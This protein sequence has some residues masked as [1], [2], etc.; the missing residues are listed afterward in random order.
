M[1]H[2][3]YQPYR[4]QATCTNPISQIISVAHPSHLI[5]F[6][7]LPSP[8]SPVE[9][10]S[11]LPLGTH[12]PSP[13]SVMSRNTRAARARWV[14][15]Y[16]RAGGHPGIPP[17]P[18][19]VTGDSPSPYDPYLVYCPHKQRPEPPPGCS[20]VTSSN[21]QVGIGRRADLNTLCSA[22][23]PHLYKL[24]GYLFDILHLT[25]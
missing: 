21:R 15:R 22:C 12:R 24:I 4:L 25:K 14:S 17:V 18:P 13:R 6:L 2:G 1:D 9:P 16:S 5:W 20:P 10:L 11:A 7:P 8:T 19:W 23:P 3:L